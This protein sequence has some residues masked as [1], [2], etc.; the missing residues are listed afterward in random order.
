MQS[1]FWQGY[2]NLPKGERQNYLKQKAEQFCTSNAFIFLVASVAFVFH[3]LALDLIGIVFFALSASVAFWI[4]KDFRPGLTITCTAIF[5]VS[6]KNSPGYGY[7]GDP[8]YYSNPWVLVPIIIAGVILIASMAVRCVKNRENYKHG[9]LYIPLAILAV[10]ITLSGVG[11]KY[12]GESFLFGLAMAL[13]YIGIYLLLI[14]CIDKFDGLFDYIATFLTVLALLISVQVVFLY[15]SH[16]LKGGSLN[17]SWKEHIVVGWGVSNVVGEMIVF[18]LPFTLYKTEK[19]KKFIFYHLVSLISVVAL[20]LTLNRA[21]MLFGLPIYA[22]LWIRMIVK[23]PERK[24]LLISAFIFAGIGI[25]CIVVL[26]LITDLSPLFNYFLR[27]FQKSDKKVSLS[28]RDKLWEQ[29]WGYFLDSPWIG[30]GFARSFNEPLLLNENSLFQSL[31]H[32]FVIQA[33]G[34]GG[35][36][37]VVAVL[38]F[39]LSLIKTYLKKYENRVYTLAFII[40]F[41]AIALLDT[42]YFITYC[43]LFLMLIT[44]TV[45]K[46]ATKED[47]KLVTEV[48]NGK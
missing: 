16:L 5:I 1:N 46:V 25:V 45:E 24:K 40:S 6:T 11:R 36:M 14:G 26:A 42:V 30:E 13:S 22:V 8:D 29:A 47:V 2:K 23:S 43:V 39:V 37:G 7:E 18:F 12:Y 41:G 20:V 31:S 34:S 19:S 35:I 15:A 27:I 21:G 32:N 9:K 33:F 10:A 3:A 48:N 28:G 4:F 38:L 17:S 44:V